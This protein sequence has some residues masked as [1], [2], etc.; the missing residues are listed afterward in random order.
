M[1]YEAKI[2]KYLREQKLPTDEGTYPDELMAQI[3]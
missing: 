3:I 2:I 1:T